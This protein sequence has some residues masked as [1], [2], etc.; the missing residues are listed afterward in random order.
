M[1]VLPITCHHNPP[2]ISSYKVGDCHVVFR[3]RLKH[4]SQWHGYWCLFILSALCL[5]HFVTSCFSF[6]PAGLHIIFLYSVPRNKSWT[7][8]ASPILAFFDFFF[9]FFLFFFFSFFLLPFTLSL[10]AFVPLLLL[11][12]HFPAKLFPWLLT[13]NPYFGYSIFYHI[14][15]SKKRIRTIDVFCPGWI[16][17]FGFVR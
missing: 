8:Y 7:I 14:I 11:R 3:L 9:S 10:C 4:S 15:L 2:V 17:V 6:V 13:R 16:V 1:S 12:C 5:C